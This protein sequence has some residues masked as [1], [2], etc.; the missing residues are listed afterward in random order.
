M[1]R[2]NMKKPER[3]VTEKI[4]RNQMKFL[5]SRLF[6]LIPP[7]LIS[8]GG[9]QVSD[10][11]DRTIEYIQSL[12]SSL[13]MSQIRKEQ[14]SS[15]KKRSHESTNSNKY[16][17]IDIQIHEMSPDLDVVLITGLTTQSDFY[18]VV[19]LLDQYS[20]EVALANFSSSGHSTFHIRHKKIET[21]EMS[22]RLMILLQGY[23]NV[24]ELENDQG[25][26][27]ELELGNDY[28]SSCDQLE[29]NLN[30]WDFDF[31]SNVWGWEL[32]GLPM[33][34]TS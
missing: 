3:K 19:R 14:L 28:A 10:R 11:V 34:I 8:K 18:D 31:Q 7:H 27:N 4:R 33:S 15:T 5:Y 13:E 21:E 24:K 29:S 23:S 25:F 6:S 17:S 12:K 22:Q 1:E 20:S 16:K 2:G 26:S 30:I 32:E 9:D